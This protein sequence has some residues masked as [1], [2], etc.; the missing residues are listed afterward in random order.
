MFDFYISLFMLSMWV[1]II[2]SKD[3]PGENIESL[4]LLDLPVTHIQHFQQHWLQHVSFPQS[5]FWHHQ[6]KNDHDS[7]IKTLTRLLMR[8]HISNFCNSISSDECAV[9][10][11]CM[12]RIVRG[13]L[14]M[15][16]NS[17]R[18]N[19][20]DRYTRLEK[21]GRSALCVARAR[22]CMR[23]NSI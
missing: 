16:S 10:C 15:Y 13:G 4:T 7:R 19:A 14:H 11:K 22:V 1:T 5:I 2:S 3:L 18:L 17:H 6:R 12:P 9:P 8:N 21:D 23:L 20:C